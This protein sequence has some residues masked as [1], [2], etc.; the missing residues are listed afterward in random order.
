[1]QRILPCLIV[2]LSLLNTASFGADKSNKP[3]EIISINPF[4]QATFNQDEKCT[5][6]FRYNLPSDGKFHIFVQPFTNG[7]R[8]K[9]AAI[10]GSR[11]YSN[12]DGVSRT[13]IGLINIEGNA[14]VD[15]IRVNMTTEDVKTIIAT[16]SRKVKL[17]W[18]TEDKNQIEFIQWARE[19]S[20]DLKAAG[21]VSEYGVNWYRPASAEMLGADKPN[22]I[23]TVPKFRKDGQKYLAFTFGNAE[24]NKFL[25]VIDFDTKDQSK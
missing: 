24:E 5:V 10:N 18:V 3:L 12:V 6:E 1:M 20:L 15:E 13:G 23:R 4:S 19:Y 9:G 7:K 14:V 2:L 17:E 25:G 8:T 21:K 16:I 22:L 11:G